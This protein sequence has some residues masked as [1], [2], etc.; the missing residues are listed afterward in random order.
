MQPSPQN[1]ILT[2]VLLAVI[3]LLL[4]FFWIK[5]EDKPL[6]AKESLSKLASL[7][8]YDQYQQG[9]FYWNLRNEPSLRKAI[10]YF[11]KAISLDS[12][13]AAAHAG[14][15]DCYTALGYGSYESPGKAF[16]KAEQAAMYALKL[17]PSLANAHT[18]LGY[19][20]FYYY[21][22]WTGAEKEFLKAQQIEPQNELSY[23]S[24]TY[25]LTAMGRFP[26]AGVSNQKAIQL[27][28]LSSPINTDKGF[29]LY[30]SGQYNDAEK[31]LGETLQINPKN[32]LTH[33]WMGRTYQEKKQF[34]KAI[35]EYR[36]TLS[37]NNNWP[38][39]W[40]AIGS[41]Y[42]FA[43]Q[44]MMAKNIIDTLLALSDKHYVTPYGI[45]LVYAS[46]NEKDKAFE[47]LNKA[48]EER[49]HWLVWLKIDPR[50]KSLRND[51]RFINLLEKIGL[52][53]MSSGE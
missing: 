19:I 36:Q 52:A 35:D 47:W 23:T 3:M 38:V 29:L 46:V 48:L 43:G 17:D 40:A 30:Y 31:T 24:Y 1:K 6:P 32:P 34:N 33:L 16:P 20:R 9:L 44:N 13:Y 39:A 50:F 27:D 11:T 5:Q 26:E 15:A 8:A 18:S 7:K 49:S 41:A 53:P 22:D 28:P 37:Y 4:I 25:F 2:F 12:N 10:T 51:M 14:I 45:A 21:W 42:G